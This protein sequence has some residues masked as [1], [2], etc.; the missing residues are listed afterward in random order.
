M[1]YAYATEHTQRGVQHTTN[2][3]TTITNTADAA[4]IATQAP[5]QCMSCIAATNTLDA[6]HKCVTCTSLGSA[7][8]RDTC[9]ACVSAG[10]SSSSSSIEG[11]CSRCL[12]ADCGDAAC[13]NARRADRSTAPNLGA[14][15][16]CFG[17]VRAVSAAPAGGSSSSSSGSRAGLCARCFER[18]SV[19][20]RSREACL[21]GVAAPA[22]SVGAAAGTAACR[23]SGV[24]DRAKCL[25]CA[26]RAG[27][28][29]AA[30]QAC[31]ACS[32]SSRVPPRW[33]CAWLARARVR[34]DACA[35][36]WCPTLVTA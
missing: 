15:E 17:C 36:A 30:G 13:L 3:R 2:T 23:N 20:P 31:G 25:A 4:N 6:R 22:A 27:A 7:A 10:S 35:H 9:V 19:P 1:L 29:V 16:R 24:A 12:D 34:C 14:V 21:A 11:D 5:A 8:A 32:T 26:A 18:D 28:S 33:V